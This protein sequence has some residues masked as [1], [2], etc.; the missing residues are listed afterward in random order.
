MPPGLHSSIY[1][2]LAVTLIS[3]RHLCNRPSDLYAGAMDPASPR[4][5]G[6][7]RDPE[8]DERVLAAAVTELA[9]RGVAEFSLTSVA[10]R[11]KAA[12]RSIYARWPTREDLM[13]AGLSTLAAGLTPPRTGSLERDM[14]I[15]L[16]KIAAVFT[17][18]RLTL[19]QRC[20]AEISQH[21]DLYAAFKRDS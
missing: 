2:T 8:L 17:E 13:L 12:K 1:A 10:T 5:R 19:L 6:R 3:G 20:V 14:A 15:L 7:P 16:D 4:P 11:A 21:P 9:E 18:P